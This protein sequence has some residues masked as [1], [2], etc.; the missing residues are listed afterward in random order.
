MQIKLGGGVLLDLGP[1]LIDLFQYLVGDPNLLFAKLE[2]RLNMSVED[3]AILVLNTLG[4]PARGIIN[5]GWYAKQGFGRMN[6]RVIVHGNAGYMSTDDISGGTYLN[7]AKA[8]YT[9]V[10]RRLTGRRIKPLA[11]APIWEAHYKALSY[12]FDCVRQDVKPTIGTS[13]EEGLKTLELVDRAY[14]GQT[15]TLSSEAVL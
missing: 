15:C 11:Y 14:H 9:N 12:F 13:A 7:A 6:F 8:V 4:S 1:H 10:F 3:G 2:H 5:V